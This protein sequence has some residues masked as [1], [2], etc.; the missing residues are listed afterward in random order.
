MSRYTMS[1]MVQ[2]HSSSSDKINRFVRT[3]LSNTLDDE[4]YA[5][6]F[7]QED[8][9]ALLDELF[10]VFGE[11]KTLSRMT[12]I[13]RAIADHFK[14][15]FQECEVAV[16]GRQ[17]KVSNIFQE[18]I[19]TAEIDK[20]SFGL[21]LFINKL[22]EDKQTY[23]LQEFLLSFPEEI[24]QKLYERYAHTSMKDDYKTLRNSIRLCVEDTFELDPKDIVLFLRKKL[25]IRY[26]VDQK[27]LKQSENRRFMGVSPEYLEE[28][29]KENFPSDFETI[30]LDMAPEV[31]SD[32][33]DFGR[34]DNLRFKATYIEVFRTL[35]D[36][37]MAEFTSSL[38]KDT[39]LALNGYVLRLH[40]DKLLYLCAQMLIDM[41]MK[42]DRKADEFLRFY[43][44]ETMVG[45]NGKKIKKPFV[46]DVQQNIWNYSSIYSVMTQCAQY[47]TQ[48]KKQI[49]AI[50]EAHGYH[51][52]S[53]QLLEVSKNNEAK[54]S[55][56]LRLVKHELQLCTT[57]KKQL[58][59]IAKPSKEELLVLK[60]KREKEKH[61]LGKH[62]KLYA[63]K[64]ELNVKLENAKVTEKNRRKQVETAQKALALLE[65]K[66]EELH[67]QQ[68][69]IFI[70]IGKALTFR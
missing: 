62:D 33:L 61:L 1:S 52:N 70:A 54:C 22:L 41:V 17:I 15:Y 67:V 7:V 24:V 27:N 38:D 47:D 63:K 14:S 44:G 23:A 4:F 51:E 28:V 59:S 25:Y 19:E 3:Y 10:G 55:Q 16:N 5:S 6:E 65:K 8:F 31:I 53:K 29:Y 18:G 32:A 50:K 58:L 66:G 45:S 21:A 42:R 64:T 11:E 9:D 2:S 40:F 60:Q 43:N 30:L 26:F 20:A 46:V 69:N 36:V 49:K 34:V 39:V 56:E 37:A 35:V 68:D 12:T 48:H 13:S 57:E